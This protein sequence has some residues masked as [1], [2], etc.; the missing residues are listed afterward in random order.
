MRLY[1]PLP[2]LDGGAD[3]LDAYRALAKNLCSSLTADGALFLEIGKGQE[4]DVRGIFE[5]EPWLF[6]SSMRDLCG[7]IRVLCFQKNN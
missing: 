3:G 1:D 4:E 2:A 5:N 6:V 7:V